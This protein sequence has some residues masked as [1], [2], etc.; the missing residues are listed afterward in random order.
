MNPIET[1]PTRFL[2]ELL[3]Y[4]P[5]IKVNGSL[6]TSLKEYSLLLV[7]MEKVMAALQCGDFEQFDAVVGENACEIRAAKIAMSVLKYL[8]A[9]PSIQ[10]QIKRA[11]Q[12]IEVLSQSLELLM[13]KGVSLHAL[14]K[15]EELDVSLT[16]DELFL[17]ESFLL[18]VAK[19]VKPPKEETPLCRNDAADPKKLKEFGKDVSTSFVDDLVRKTRQ[20]LSAA[21]VAFV[22]AQAQLLGDEQLKRMCSQ[23]FVVNH[24]SWLCIP[25]FWTYK[26]LLLAAQKKGIPLVFYVKFLAQDKGFEVVDEECLL[27]QSAF[28][29]R[30]SLAYEEVIPCRRDL[31]KVAIIVQGAVCANGDRLPSK[32][33]WKKAIASQKLDVILAGAADHRQYPNSEEDIRI[34]QLKDEEFESYRKLARNAGYALE[35]PTMFFIQHVY[36]ATGDRL[37]L[38]VQKTRLAEKLL[39][40]FLPQKS[41]EE[42]P[43][44]AV[45]R[46]ISYW[47]D[48][49]DEK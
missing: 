17:I 33:Q 28:D 5:S 7:A 16:E 18:S 42:W 22:Q 35:N 36:L 27:L 38:L 40:A 41:L 6:R 11:K 19:T 1:T 47:E 10:A 25:M 29:G 2:S 13:K 15:E 21:S 34:E 26:T 8:E 45:A 46:I 30:S 23:E 9:V 20:L 31:A 32:S 14:L 43:P 44:R 3:P 37:P 4:D 24:N 48:K 49:G 12:K 39:R